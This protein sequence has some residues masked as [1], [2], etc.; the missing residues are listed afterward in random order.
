MHS[1]I[2]IIS[3]G[4]HSSIQD[5]GRLGGLD[6]GVSESGAMDRFAYDCANAIV[7]N[8]E[9]TPTLE[10]LGGSFIGSVLD[11]VVI[12]VTGAMT[13]MKINS[14]HARLW[15]SYLLNKGDRIEL[16]SC[17][18][19]IRN[20]MAIQG[21][22]GGV[23]K[24]LGSYSTDEKAKIGGISGRGLKRGDLLSVEWTSKAIK[25][26]L[27][28]YDDPYFSQMKSRYKEVRVLL[29][30]Q[31]DAFDPAGIEAFFSSEYEMTTMSNRMG[32]RLNGRSIEHVKSPDILS[33]AI[34]FGAIQ[35]PGDGQPIIMM[36]D[37]QTTGG[38]T[39]I[40][41]VVSTDLP[42]LAQTRPGELIRFI[43]IELHELK[44]I[45]FERII[46]KEKIRHIKEETEIFS[47][48]RFKV[49]VNNQHYELLVEEVE[50]V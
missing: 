21:N 47:S 40:G 42:V 14:V 38:Y 32:L 19:G 30:P 45:D 11:P 31:E 35:I 36:A 29:G 43:R 34:P 24:F 39:K 2:E 3:P 33:D 22:W 41:T 6:Y 26:Y 15:E 25:R 13:K 4:I 9:G 50:S 17:Q 44:T 37:R 10:I 28:L 23:E 7:G 48:K 46:R 49:T 5:R 12:C 8:C 27:M 16:E 1:R 18:V 20:Y